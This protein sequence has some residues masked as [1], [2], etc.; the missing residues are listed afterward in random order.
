MFPQKS[1]TRPDKV[2]IWEYSLAYLFRFSVV[3]A[4]CFSGMAFVNAPCICIQW[5]RK[6]GREHQATPSLW[7]QT[8]VERSRALRILFSNTPSVV[9]GLWRFGG[10]RSAHTSRTEPANQASHRC[11]RN[12][13]AHWHLNAKP[14]HVGLEIWAHADAFTYTWLC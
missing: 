5:W 4:S 3:F 8:S 2:L 14:S 9:Q 11:M 1:H 13:H 7:C 6:G 10:P 12:T